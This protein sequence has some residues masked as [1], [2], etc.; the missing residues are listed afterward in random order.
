MEEEIFLNSTV[1]LDVGN[2]SSVAERLLCSE[3]AT[4]AAAEGLNCSGFAVAAPQCVDDDDEI[5]VI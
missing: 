1:D 2:E 5:P 4:V 3:N